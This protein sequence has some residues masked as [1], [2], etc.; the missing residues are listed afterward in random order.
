MRG[1]FAHEACPLFHSSH[2]ATYGL[3]LAVRLIQMSQKALTKTSSPVVLLQTYPESKL[4]DP[5]FFSP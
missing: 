4:E 5:S 2:D 3:G 1:L